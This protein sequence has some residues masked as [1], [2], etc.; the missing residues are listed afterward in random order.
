MCVELK[1]NKENLGGEVTFDELI[2]M[3]WKGQVDYL[4]VH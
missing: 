3:G 1:D 4:I 2:E